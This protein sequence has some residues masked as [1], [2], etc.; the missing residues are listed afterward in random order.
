M[1]ERLTDKALQ[2][3]ELGEAMQEW[4]QQVDE[5][6]SAKIKDATVRKMVGIGGG[7]NESA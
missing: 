5:E 6:V 4:R 1:A 3:D 2:A 7:G